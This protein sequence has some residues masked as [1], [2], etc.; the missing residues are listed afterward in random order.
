MIIPLNCSVPHIYATNSLVDLQRI[1]WGGY[2]LLHKG[3]TILTSYW[4]KKISLVSKERSLAAAAAKKEVI[5]VMHKLSRL[6]V[7]M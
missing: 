5:A 3:G 4:L 6:L 2:L 7:K 1:L